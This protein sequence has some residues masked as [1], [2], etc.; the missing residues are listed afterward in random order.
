MKLKFVYLPEVNGISEWGTGSV[1]RTF[2]HLSAFLGDIFFWVAALWGCFDCSSR[3]CI[4]DAIL[5]LKLVPSPQKLIFEKPEV[6][7]ECRT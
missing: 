7:D 3:D 6:W 2:I 1:V 4:V 5:D